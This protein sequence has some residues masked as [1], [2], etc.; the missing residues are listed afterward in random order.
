MVTPF[1]H[2]YAFLAPATAE[3]NAEQTH[4]FS[5]DQ[6]LSA[7]GQQIEANLDYNLIADDAIDLTSLNY[8]F[9]HTGA[10]FTGNTLGGTLAVSNGTQSFDISLLG[11]FTNSTFMTASDGTGGTLVL[12][13]TSLLSPPQL[14]LAAGGTS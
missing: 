10:S 11:N 2:Q 6:H 4:F 14:S 7:A 9:G 12:N 1:N 13:Q 3:G 5:D 8:V